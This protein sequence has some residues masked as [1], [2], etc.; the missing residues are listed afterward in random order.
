MSE[1]KRVSATLSMP[2]AYADELERIARKTRQSKSK[3]VREWV[4]LF[5]DLDKPELDVDLAGEPAMQR[6]RTRRAP[7]AT[8]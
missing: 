4:E 5:G 2:P 3:L 8:P 6:V 7:G 1:S